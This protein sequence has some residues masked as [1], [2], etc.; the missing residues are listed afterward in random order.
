MVGRSFLE[1]MSGSCTTTTT[2]FWKRLSRKWPMLLVLLL[3]TGCWEHVSEGACIQEQWIAKAPCLWTWT[4][5]SHKMLDHFCV[6]LM[7]EWLCTTT[8]FLSWY[9]CFLWGIVCVWVSLLVCDMFAA[10]GLRLF[11]IRSRVPQLQF[12]RSM[13][14]PDSN[15]CAWCSRSCHRCGKLLSDSF[16]VEEWTLLHC[17]MST[18]RLENEYC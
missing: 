8:K 9:R 3:K 5:L 18:V 17:R 1:M 13:H 10:A 11:V 14:C 2:R 12:H 16:F 15:S 7:F 6:L 4:C